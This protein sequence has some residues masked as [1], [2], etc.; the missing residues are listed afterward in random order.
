ML[1]HRIEPGERDLPRMSGVKASR[2]IPNWVEL[3]MRDDSGR[4][5][6]AGLA[7]AVSFFTEIPALDEQSSG[8]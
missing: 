8:R 3:L 1:M 4:N 2:S 6:M 5:G 7:L